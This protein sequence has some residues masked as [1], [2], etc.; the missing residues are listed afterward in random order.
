MAKRKIVDAHHHFWQLSRGYNYPWLQ[1]APAG[2]GMLGDLAPIVRDYGLA[3]YLTDTKNYDVVG[4]VHVEAV[5]RD[6]L[7]ETRWLHALSGRLPSA[8]VAFA[9]LDAPDAEQIIATQAS[10]PRVKGIRQIVNWHPNP[11]LTFTPRNLLADDAWRSGYRLLRK[12]GLSF[13]MQLY[14]VQMVDA[15]DVARRYPDTL[16]IVN[17][18]G[19]PADRNTQGIADWRA[20]LKL[21][22]A[23]ENVVIKV[24]GFGMVD[25]RWTPE[26]IRPLILHAVDCFGVDRV[27]FASNFP[28]DRLY[29][30]FADVYRAFEMIVADFSP[31]EQDR[32]FRGNALR[33][34]RI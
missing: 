14:A 29:G 23:T 19:M 11:S 9:A 32:M 12:Y 17:H 16:M 33:H 5:P 26:S 20:G 3:D 31:D 6:P 27:M 22:A 10:F 7:D 13:D 15:A 24:S 4:S 1:D 34:Y 18:A 30:S 25:H 28:V 2:E 8:I 21:L